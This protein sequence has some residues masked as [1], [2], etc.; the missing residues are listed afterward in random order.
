MNTPSE[1]NVISRLII[2][3][4]MSSDAVQYLENSCLNNLNDVFLSDAPEKKEISLRF[5][6]KDNK[7]NA[8]QNHVADCT[9]SWTGE[10][11]IQDDEGNVWVPNKLGITMTLGSMYSAAWEAFENR[12]ECLAL[13][14]DLVDDIR[15]ISSKPIKI[16]TLNNEQRIER[17]LRNKKQAISDFL[18]KLLK[19][20]TY[21]FRRNLRVHGRGRLIPRAA[22]TDKV[23]PGTY[24]A[25][26]NDGT[27][28]RPRIKRYSVFMPENSA[29][30]ALVKRI[31]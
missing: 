13:V 11:E 18:S 19:E 27:R 5:R 28:R 4:I 8:W 9:M 30:G 16:M 20:N 14:R 25:L 15:Q 12:M 6:I 29:Y 22:L 10:C 26:V 24:E 1:T 31:E 7:P 2:Q 17:D 3:K 23:E 21:E